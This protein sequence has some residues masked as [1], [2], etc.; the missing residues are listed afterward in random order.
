[1]PGRSGNPNGRPKGIA[2]LV[3]ARTKD[4]KELVE[5]MVKIAQGEKFLTSV[6]TL[7]GLVEQAR[8][9]NLRERMEA[10]AWL[11]DRGWG[12]PVEEITV[13]PGQAFVVQHRIYAPGR[14]PLADGEQTLPALPERT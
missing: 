7:A 13:Q 8:I 11:A 12:K 1:M 10:I 6:A 14:D 2:H 9:P 3:Q 5:T 4:G